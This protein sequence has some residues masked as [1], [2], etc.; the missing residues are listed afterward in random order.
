MAISDNKKVATMVN[1]VGQEA[2]VMRD[3][4][5]R[6]MAV[7]T[8]FQVVN[9]D[10]QGTPLEGNLSAVNAAIDALSADLSGPVWD[11]MIAAIVPSHKNTALD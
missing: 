8:K 3:A 5:T 7:R 10:V 9:P 1:I 2:L 6:I 11:G 4:M